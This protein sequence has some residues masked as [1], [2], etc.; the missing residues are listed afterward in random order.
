LRHLALNARIAAMPVGRAQH[1]RIASNREARDLAD[2]R[3]ADP[4]EKTKLLKV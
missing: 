3:L 4:D 2:S 1:R